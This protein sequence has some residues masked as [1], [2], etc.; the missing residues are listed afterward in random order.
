MKLNAQTQS[1]GSIVVDLSA[2]KD[3]LLEVKTAQ[4]A[5]DETTGKL[6]YQNIEAAQADLDNKTFT[7]RLDTLGVVQEDGSETAVVLDV[8]VSSLEVAPYVPE[9]TDPEEGDGG[10]V[11]IESTSKGDGDQL[12][13]TSDALPQATLV[14]VGAI[15]LL[16]AAGVVL[17]GAHLARKR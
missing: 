4:G 15:A 6:V 12:V 3:R 1:D 8:Q 10:T 5:Y 13:K 16:A 14:V 9:P 2:W 11:V 17:S 7:Y